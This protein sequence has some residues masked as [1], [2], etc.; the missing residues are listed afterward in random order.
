MQLVHLRVCF[1][2]LLI[3]GRD[4]SRTPCLA[5]AEA[6]I[7]PLLVATTEA[8]LTCAAMAPTQSPVKK[9]AA[10]CLSL[11]HLAYQRYES[12]LPWQP[13]CAGSAR[14]AGQG[15]CATL[16]SSA[17][18][19]TVRCLV[20]AHAR[21]DVLCSTHTCVERGRGHPGGREAGGTGSRPLS[22]FGA[23]QRTAPVYITDWGNLDT[24]KLISLTVFLIRERGL[25]S[26][27]CH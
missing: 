27:A 26:A 11:P 21:P 13:L 14:W 5:E 23:L 22:C 17:A 1:S 19:S 6:G 4:A 8:A 9:T 20:K 10:S 18:Y 16:R 2:K 12:C 25:R 24:V 15:S 7:P 3:A